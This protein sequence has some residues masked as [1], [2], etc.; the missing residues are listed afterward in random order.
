MFATIIAVSWVILVMAPLISPG[1]AATCEF[2]ENRRHHDGQ[3]IG[4]YGP[5]AYFVSQDSNTKLPGYATVTFSGQPTGHGRLP[6]L[7]CLP[8]QKPET[9]ATACRNL[10]YVGQFTI[11][12]NLTMATRISRALCARL[13]L[14]LAPNH[15][16]AHAVTGR[17]Q[18]PGSPAGSFPMRISG[19][20][21]ARTCPIPDNRE[22]GCECGYQRRVFDPSAAGLTPD[23]ILAV[24][25]TNPQ[26]LGR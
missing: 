23:W 1:M 21:C 5:T 12:V 6:R 20:D 14:R 22:R 18:Q 24:P 16:C 4:A 25:N 10:V 7:L 13:D 3:W 26:F 9:R 15:Q 17:P 11:D 8:L 19:L 2:H